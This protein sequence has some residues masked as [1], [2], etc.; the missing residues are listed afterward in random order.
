LRLVVK[1]GLT[2]SKLDGSSAVYNSTMDAGIS[3]QYIDTWNNM[4]VRLLWQ[5]V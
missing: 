1:T 2:L 5:A 4:Q 3:T